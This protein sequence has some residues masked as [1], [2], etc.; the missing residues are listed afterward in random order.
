MK[1]DLMRV[2]EVEG[3][4]QFLE[5][6]T[7]GPW[8][9]GVD[10]RDCGVNDGSDP[11]WQP[12][13]E[14][15]LGKCIACAHG[16]PLIREY[17]DGTG[18]TRHIHRW[19]RRLDKRK[20]WEDLPPGQQEGMTQEKFDKFEGEFIDGIYAPW[21]WI[22]SAATQNTVV[23]GYSQEEG[24]IATSR[25]DAEFIAR[26]REWVPRL[27]YTLRMLYG[28][29][30]EYIEFPEEEIDQLREQLQ[31]HGEIVTTR[32]QGGFNGYVE[33]QRLVAPWREWLFVAKA[34]R[35]MNLKDHPYPSALTDQQ[36][37]EIGDNPLD[38]L[39]LRKMW[40]PPVIRKSH[41]PNKTGN[42]MVGEWEQ[43][44][45]AGE[46]QDETVSGHNKEDSGRGGREG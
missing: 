28:N 35:Y 29:S 20:Q 25:A 32:V 26:S 21:H 3:I 27:L 33:G 19:D 2:A 38:V 4:E 17:T 7:P 45:Q 23:G 24:G 42:Q 34:E 1:I 14:I 10:Y 31:Q 43:R 5:Q 36:K 22:T 9:E 11:S 39:Y 40:E 41:T 13:P 6:V 46:A 15:P 37:A 44:I 16:D 18:V 8:E 12:P 30:S